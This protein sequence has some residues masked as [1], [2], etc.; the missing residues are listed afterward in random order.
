MHET[1]ATELCS[2]R[3]GKSQTWLV[4]LLRAAAAAG[5]TDMTRL[6]RQSVK[7]W[8]GPTL[9]RNSQWVRSWRLNI[10]AATSECGR[11]SPVDTRCCKPATSSPV[12][13][14]IQSFSLAVTEAATCRSWRPW[15]DSVR[16]YVPAR[17]VSSHS[18]TGMTSNGPKLSVLCCSEE[19]TLPVRLCLKTNELGS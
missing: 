19:A 9:C 1:I 6:T 17:P 11:K 12:F 13:F 8:T 2:V 7:D 5:M 14:H 10:E 15:L 16:Q 18:G 3:H 4:A